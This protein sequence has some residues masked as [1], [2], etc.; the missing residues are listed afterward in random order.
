MK[1]KVIWVSLAFFGRSFLALGFESWV[2]LA[3]WHFGFFGFS[4]FFG[5]FGIL[6]V[7]LEFCGIW[8]SLALFFGFLFSLLD[9][10]LSFGFWVFF[11][12][13]SNFGV[14]ASFRFVLQSFLLSAWLLRGDDEKREEKHLGSF[15]VSSFLAFEDI[16]VRGLWSLV[17]CF[18]FCLFSQDVALLLTS[19]WLSRFWSSSLLGLWKVEAA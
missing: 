17:L 19:C 15:F 8:V 1:K 3:F 14:L 10:F 16:E 5:T 7:W 18:F 9:F 2:F 13:L 12:S 6:G 4:R 11:F